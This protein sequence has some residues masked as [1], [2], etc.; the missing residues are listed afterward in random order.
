MA[1]HKQAIADCET[2]RKVAEAA[3]KRLGERTTRAKRRP[4]E[5]RRAA[6][7]ELTAARERLALQRATA[8][9]DELAVKAEADG[10][11]ARRATG[12]VA[13]LGAELAR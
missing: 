2:H 5:A 7:A 12:L 8:T 10:E 11:E 6:Q 13:D 9:D 1:A 4:R 3:A